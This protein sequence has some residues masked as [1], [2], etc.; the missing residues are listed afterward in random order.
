MCATFSWLIYFFD[1]LYK[2][3]LCFYWFSA[4]CFYCVVLIVLP[5]D[6]KNAKLCV[7]VFKGTCCLAAT[8][9]SLKFILA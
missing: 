4:E 1:I 2:S 3:V 9:L 8:T 7:S 5:V 6:Y